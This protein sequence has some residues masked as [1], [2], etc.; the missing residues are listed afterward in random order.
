MR[1][2]VHGTIVVAFLLSTSTPPPGQCARPSVPQISND[3]SDD[4]D[5]HIPL[6]A[7]PLGVNIGPSLEVL[8]FAQDAKTGELPWVARRGWLE[9][10]DVLVS[11]VSLEGEYISEF[12]PGEFAEAMKKTL[13][14]KK[15]KSGQL[16]S[17]DDD[18]AGE[19]ITLRVRP[20]RRPGRPTRNHGMY[21]PMTKEEADQVDATLA[22]FGSEPD[23]CD[24]LP[25][26]MAT[27]E[28]GCS[29]LRNTHQAE[30][31]HVLVRRGGC[32]FLAKAL[33]V[34]SSGGRSLV[35]VDEGAGGLR[36]EADQG[37]SVGIPVVMVSK[38]DA[39]SRLKASSNAENEAPGAEAARAAGVGSGQTTGKLAADEAGTERQS[40]AS[41]PG[42]RTRGEAR[43]AAA[44]EVTVA[45]GGDVELVVLEG[46]VRPI[47]D[48]G[49]EEARRAMATT[50]GARTV[51][52]LPPDADCSVERQVR[53]GEQLGS[54]MLVVIANATDDANIAR[55]VSSTTDI[56]FTRTSFMGDTSPPGY[57]EPP[58]TLGSL[59]PALGGSGRR[60]QRVGGDT[61]HGDGRDGGALEGDG[62]GPGGVDQRQRLPKTGGGDE[63]RRGRS[64]GG[65]E[66][67]GAICPPLTIVVGHDDGKRVLEWQQTVGGGAVTASV[68]ER[69]NVGKLWGDVVWASDPANWPKGL[70]KR[71]RI[72]NRLRKTHSPEHAGRGGGKDGAARRKA[73]AT[74]WSLIERYAKDAEAA[75]DDVDIGA[76]PTAPVKGRFDAEL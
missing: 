62:E 25:V 38:Q 55:L 47:A 6:W 33:I 44:A 20:G 16:S 30:G 58:T 21:S 2:P 76:K 31:A 72:L 13:E 45:G 24:A 14:S 4:Y 53:L 10:G 70:K 12:S 67:E 46:E 42:T 19:F 37:E 73:S 59:A 26:V 8:S 66:G 27:P 3:T 9:V 61:A 11:L 17:D 7:I 15:T 69:E 51:V 18:D 75:E 48:Q 32:S 1:N 22:A 23:G 68:E 57:T 52:L 36:M 65:P 39:P 5:I 54:A 35:V 63:G 40:D 56:V 41:Q 29:P 71:R 43:G 64:R 34:S 28:N 74:R 50:N 49:W 60:G